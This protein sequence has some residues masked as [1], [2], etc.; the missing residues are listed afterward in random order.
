MDIGDRW[1]ESETQRDP[2]TGRLVRRLTTRGWLNQTPTYHTNSGFSA[3]GRW[4]ALVSV[5]EGAT[6]VLRAD[7]ATGELTTIWRAPGSGDRNYIHRGMGLSGPAVNGRGM[8]GNRLCLAPRSC[9][10]V[11]TCERQLLTVDLHTGDTRVL[12]EDV[13]QDWIYGAPAV[14]PDE[15]WVAI[16]LSSAHPELSAGLAVTRPYTSFPDHRLRLTAVPL[17]GDGPARILY[18]REGAQSAHCAYCPTD[19]EL[20]YFDLDLAPRYWEGSDGRTPRIWLL[21]LRT[22]QA[23]PLKSAYPGPFQVHQAWLWD[24]SAM[25]YHGYLPGGGVYIGIAERDG[26]TRWE[27][28]FPEARHYGH[29]T[30]DPCRPA[31]ILDGDFVPDLLQRL[32]YDRP[33]DAPPRLEPICVHGSEWESIP[34]QYSHPHPLVDASGRWLSFNRAQGGRSDVCLVDLA[35]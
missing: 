15:A 10:A 30:P 11:L 27:R 28:S 8:A 14:S 18:E 19:G 21:D 35:R 3:D 17:D 25:A 34:G 16:A 29:L 23:R 32:Y 12:I 26:R 2:L 20:L 13:G 4:L 33:D 5:R 6:W 7:T 31:L 24:G 22:G 1:N 9:R